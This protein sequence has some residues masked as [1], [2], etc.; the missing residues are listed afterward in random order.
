[1]KPPAPRSVQTRSDMDPPDSLSALADGQAKDLDAALRLW[2]DDPQARADWHTYHLI[3]DVMRSDELASSPARDA[4]FMAGL[5][6]R[7]AQEP[8]VLAPAPVA[9]PVAVGG[10]RLP[11]AVAAGFVVVAGVLVVARM[12]AGGAD[13]G[14]A[15]LAAASSAQAGSVVVR[16]T[17]SGQALITDPRLDEFLRAHQAAGGNVAA[18]APGGTLRRVEVV[19]PAEAGR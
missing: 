13:G 8:V 3:G 2:R 19:V 18:A 10:W 5:R 11:V 15:E 1:M 6:E 12:G 9:A 14:S 16:Q 7:L 4:A 17:G